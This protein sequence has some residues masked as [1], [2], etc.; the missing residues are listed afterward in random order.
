MYFD[1]FPSVEYT[2]IDNGDPKTV[3]NLLR[4]ISV[5][6]PV[7]S[8]AIIMNKHNVRDGET[9]ESLAFDYYGDASLHWV[10][11]LTNNIYDR[12][13]Q[14]PKNTRQFLAYVNDKYTDPNGLHHYEIDQSSGDT[15]V[16]INIGT[17]KTSHAAATTVTNIE[18]EE[19]EQDKKRRIRLLDPG[20]V[21]V[22]VSS[23]LQLIKE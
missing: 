16:K 10:I 2:N 18:Y 5:R 9:P 13:H 14:W 15:T 3:T 8:N 1:N 23:Y 17:D 6:D 19:S 20:Y 4:R 21:S 7:K 12:Y 22:F 11:L